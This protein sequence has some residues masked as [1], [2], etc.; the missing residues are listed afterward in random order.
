MNLDLR[1]RIVFSTALALAA[2]L[3]G[4]CGPKQFILGEFNTPG[5]P[6]YVCRAGPS[7]DWGTCTGDPTTDE[8]RWN[9]SGTVRASFH[10]PFSPCDTGIQRILIQN[11]QSSD[12]TILV[13]CAPPRIQ[14]G[15]AG[16]APAP[17]PTPRR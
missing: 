8:T 2:F 3:S 17:V 7:G 1:Y 4:C 14:V 10:A 6:A 13:E 16:P 11:P 15:G 9:Q 12:T 5:T